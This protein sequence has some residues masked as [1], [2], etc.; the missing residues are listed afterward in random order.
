MMGCESSDSIVRPGTV[1][2]LRSGAKHSASCLR[3]TGGMVISMNTNRLS[4]VAS[5]I[6]EPARTAMLLAL[7]DAAH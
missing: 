4:H 6:G 3:H 5:L 2:M 1:A 7:M